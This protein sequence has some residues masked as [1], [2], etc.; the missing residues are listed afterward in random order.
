MGGAT[1]QWMWRWRWG[2]RSIA[3]ETAG[4]TIFEQMERNE[5]GTWRWRS[6]SPADPSDC[7][8]HM[9]RTIR[10]QAQELTQ[11]HRIVRHLAHLMDAWVVH[12]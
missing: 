5:Y 3:A 7:T 4:A 2:R 1:R 12:E 8:S 11:L 10:Q 9:E 6:D